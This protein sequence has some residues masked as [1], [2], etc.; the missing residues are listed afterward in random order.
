MGDLSSAI[1]FYRRL[2][3]IIDGDAVNDFTTVSVTNQTPSDEVTQLLK[4]MMT[5]E[6]IVGIHDGSKPPQI[7]N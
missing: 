2:M 5:R 4:H 6:Y 1:G 7:S 3:H